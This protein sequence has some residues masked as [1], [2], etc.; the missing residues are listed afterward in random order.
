MRKRENKTFVI[1]RL[2]LINSVK[3]IS[4]LQRCIVEVSE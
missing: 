3:V 1:I 4:S 2:S